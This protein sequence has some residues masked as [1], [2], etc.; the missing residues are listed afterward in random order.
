[1]GKKGDG[2]NHTRMA[3]R[4]TPTVRCLLLGLLGILSLIAMA[5]AA[6]SSR[7]QAGAEQVGDRRGV[8]GRR[9]RV[10]FTSFRPGNWDIYLFEQPAQPPRRLTSDA[11]LDYDP[12]VSP[13]GRWLVFCS[14]RRGNP[15]LFVLDLK[16]QNEARLLIDSDAL[17]DQPVFSPDGRSIAFVSTV[18]GNADIYRLPFRP[19][20]T[21][22]MTDAR[23]VTRHVSG[24]FRPAFSPDGQS[25]AFSSDRDLP[26]NA[27][28][29]IVRLRDG[30]IYVVPL[31]D[32]RLTRLTSAPGWD[33]SPAWS[34]DGRTIAYYHAQPRTAATWRPTLSQIWSMKADGTS[35][36]VLTPKETTALSPTFIGGG[37]IAYSRKSA[38]GLWQLVSINPDGSDERIDSDR[39]ENSYWAPSQ[40]D[41]PGRLVA[42]G[43]GPFAPVTDHVQT[44]GILNLGDGPFL[45]AGAPFAKK[46]ADREIELYPIRF[47]TALLN[48]TKNLVLLTTAPGGTDLLVSR[49]DGSQP[50]KLWTFDKTQNA[51][52]SLSW[53]RDGEWIGFTRGNSRNRDA[54]ADIWRIK[55]DGSEPHNLTPNSPGN[56]SYPSFSGDDRRIVFRS[57]R[58]GQ[59]DL[60]L[61]NAD[62]SNVRR[63]TNSTD[64]KLFPVLSPAGN[65]IAFLSDRDRP[66][67][68]VYDIY[69]LDFSSDGRPGRLQQVT[70]N[71]V[72]EGHLAFSYDGK[73]LM[74]ASEQGGNNDEEPLVQS[75]LFGP[76]SY[77]DMYAY[78][79]SD[80]TLV[81]L[82]HNK[83]EEGVPSW[84]APV[85]R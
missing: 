47:F 16:S 19:D 80:R 18:S 58:D 52:A 37:R 30:D 54:E 5:P 11:G 44:P 71:D 24:D 51:F 79:L 74:F 49:V 84:E 15:D 4:S 64:D 56:D 43:T 45:A 66:G 69:L 65:Q 53:S 2:H 3:Q 83:W 70:R 8:S 67:S 10:A 76:Q 61:M 60:Y 29:P 75:I 50:R 22:R 57:K 21:A 32:S 82:T 46:L 6:L 20:R 72:Q 38:D 78:R 26:I 39:S 68:G 25:I 81:R 62:G 73:W 27:I 36:R 28:S 35:Q 55:T 59:V 31:E 1:M 42:H 77:G 85:A 9:D 34:A 17:E 33:G 13:D 40:G 14:E 12:V 48:P 23:N 41:A 7:S 63:V